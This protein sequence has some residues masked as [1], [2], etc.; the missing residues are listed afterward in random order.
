M[1]H[2]FGRWSPGSQRWGQI[3]LF[4]HCPDRSN[5]TSSSTWITR[6]PYLAAP[7]SLPG[8][9]IR[10]KA[11]RCKQSGLYGS[12]AST[13]LKKP[14]LN[15]HLVWFDA[16]ATLRIPYGTRPPQ[17]ILLNFINPAGE[18]KP[19]QIDVNGESIFAGAIPS[20]NWCEAFPLP[21]GSGGSV[22]VELSRPTRELLLVRGITL[23]DHVPDMQLRDVTADPLP[24]SGY[25]S[26]LALESPLYP[27]TLA[28]S[29]MGTVRIIGDEF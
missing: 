8:V 13:I 6:T 10:L 27:Q 1:V 19:L 17:A 16:D 24:A 9:L 21:V 5:Q 25:R 29:T 15:H 11:G 14:P 20:G 7:C 22:N 12:A 3:K 18:E 26:Q 4:G 2:S 28:R 23:L